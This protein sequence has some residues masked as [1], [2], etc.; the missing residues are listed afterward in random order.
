METDIR[1]RL[2]D[3]FGAAEDKE[4]DCV[5]VT[6]PKYNYICP[7]TRKECFINPRIANKI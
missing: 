6:E 2:N 5:V 7:H 1:T 3:K 4:I